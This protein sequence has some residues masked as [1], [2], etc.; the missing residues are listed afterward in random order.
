MNVN[1]IQALAAVTNARGIDIPRLRRITEQ[2]V[3]GL[4]YLRETVRV[5]PW[6]GWVGPELSKDCARHG[7]ETAVEPCLEWEEWGKGEDR[8]GV[9]WWDS[10]GEV[11]GSDDEKEMTRGR[12]SRGFFIVSAVKLRCQLR[13]VVSLPSL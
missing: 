12:V 6:R 10:E 9:A 11:E 13:R 5:R 2:F 8:D 4:R 3:D 1:F 7:N